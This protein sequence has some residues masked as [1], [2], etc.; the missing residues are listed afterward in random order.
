MDLA[1]SNVCG[2]LRVPFFIHWKYANSNHRRSLKNVRLSNSVIP[3]SYVLY[4]DKHEI[5]YIKIISRQK[6]KNKKKKRLID[7]FYFDRTKKQTES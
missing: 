6:G 7:Q 3:F 1:E 5:L 2:L 4:F